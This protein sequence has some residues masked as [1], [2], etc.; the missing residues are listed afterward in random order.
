MSDPKE[1][2]LKEPTFDQA[3]VA[4]SKKIGELS[5]ELEGFHAKLADEE[6]LAKAI[7]QVIKRYEEG[8]ISMV[9]A[10]KTA[11]AALAWMESTQEACETSVA[12]ETVAY[13]C[14]RCHDPVVKITLKCDVP[15]RYCARCVGE[16][17]RLLTL[18]NRRIN[19]EGRNGE[20]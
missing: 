7:Y 1:V 2:E 9:D 10:R 8:P 4:F 12:P 15:R 18:A 5:D 16:I 17:K 3:V 19:R 20:D 6:G 14:Q 13:I 11:R